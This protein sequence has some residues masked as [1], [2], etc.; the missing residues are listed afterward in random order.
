MINSRFWKC[1]LLVCC[2]GAYNMLTIHGESRALS[3]GVS[4]GAG[5]Q[6][7]GKWLGFRKSGGDEERVTVMIITSWV[8]GFIFGAE[9]SL[10]DDRTERAIQLI[11]DSESIQAWVDK[12][13]REHPIDQVFHGAVALHL[14]IVKKVQALGK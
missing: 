10:G 12:Y 6:S 13:C 1:S 7:C 2:L 5:S 8:Q 11:P 14:E 9:A 4:L 3:Q